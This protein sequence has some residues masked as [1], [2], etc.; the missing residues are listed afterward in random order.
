MSEKIKKGKKKKAADSVPDL[1]LKCL[2]IFS[3]PF[4]SPGLCY[5]Q[6]AS[7]L[8]SFQDSMHSC[9]DITEDVL[10]SFGYLCRS[11]WPYPRILGTSSQLEQNFILH[12]LRTGRASSSACYSKFKKASLNIWISP[13]VAT[14]AH[15][16]QSF[17]MMILYKCFIAGCYVWQIS[18]GRPNSGGNVVYVY[19]DLVRSQGLMGSLP[20]LSHAFA[21]MRQVRLVDN[22]KSSSMKRYRRFF[23]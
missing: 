8:Q 13:E 12:F 2:G 19:S 3:K 7:E 16:L 23:F 17:L 1:T 20:L 11:I 4:E 22:V 14:K 10:E 21:V 6:G 15:H 18:E 5:S 9:W